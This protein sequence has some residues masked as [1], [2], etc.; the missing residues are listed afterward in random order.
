MMTSNLLAIISKNNFNSAFY[1]IS[2]RVHFFFFSQIMTDF[3]VIV[4]TR[5]L[6]NDHAF[7][8]YWGDK[9]LEGKCEFTIFHCS[10]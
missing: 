6:I 5:V 7:D 1:F 9:V 8:V 3:A 10:T 2:V 4:E